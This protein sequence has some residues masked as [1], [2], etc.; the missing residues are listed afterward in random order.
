MASSSDLSNPPTAK[1]KPP[2]T[3]NPPPTTSTKSHSTT[4]TTRSAAP[5]DSESAPTKAS[6]DESPD[7]RAAGERQ[8]KW[9]TLNMT[10]EIPLGDY[11]L[12]GWFER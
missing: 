12:E 3:P 9:R 10:Y 6:H 11:P 4:R 1:E 5:R 2:S 7:T 8:E